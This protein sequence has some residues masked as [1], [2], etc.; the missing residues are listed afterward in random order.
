M[1]ND[2]FHQKCSKHS[3]I[4]QKSYTYRYIPCYPKY[5]KNTFPCELS[6]ERIVQN[7][8]SHKTP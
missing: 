5:V 8:Y 3:K 2:D 7:F 4:C 6:I 1:K